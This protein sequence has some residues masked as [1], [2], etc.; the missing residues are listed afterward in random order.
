MGGDHGCIVAI[1]GTKVALGA[2]GNEKIT[3]L[4]LVGHE[5]EIKAALKTA[6]CKDSRIRIV[7]ASQVLTMEDK[8]VDGIRKKKDCSILRAVELIKEQK[9]EAVISPGNTGGLVAASTIRLRQLEGVERPSIA[10][11]IPTEKSE[12]LLLD[13]GATP[14]SKPVHLLHSAI[15]GGIYAREMLGKRRPR[16]GILSNG[17]EDIKGNDLVREAN[18]LCLQCG[19]PGMEYLEFVEGHDL[20]ADQVDVVVT[21]GFVGNI[22]LKTV[23]SMG[24]GFKRMLKFQFNK[25]I[26]RMAGGALAKGVFKELKS[27]MD[28]EEHGGAPLLG[29][30][31]NVIKVHGSAR[32]RM[33]TNAIRQCTE[34]LSHHLNDHILREVG[35]ANAKV[36]L[37][38]A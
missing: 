26:L 9:A 10:C 36:T 7:H 24:L 38:P 2:P 4:H 20:F 23:E 37:V 17:K 32:Q 12:F 35:A 22:V 31:G 8:P 15:M 21:D 6:H 30:N 13:G 14:D 19:M 1:Q 16:V 18:K 27:R 28:P 34:A 3:E 25:N 29:L 5:D 33:F 11:I